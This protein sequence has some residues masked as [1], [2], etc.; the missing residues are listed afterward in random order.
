MEQPSI[1]YVINEL[2][3]NNINNFDLQLGHA[4]FAGLELNPLL[5]QLVP[6]HVVLMPLHSRRS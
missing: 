2:D 4:S 3:L 5:F 6:G 1:N